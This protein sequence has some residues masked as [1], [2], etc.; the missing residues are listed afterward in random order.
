[1]ETSKMDLSE[2]QEENA[3]QEPVKNLQTTDRSNKNKNLLDQEIKVLE[4][5]QKK[6]EEEKQA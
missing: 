6:R 5:R 3:I 4:E 2:I 1:M